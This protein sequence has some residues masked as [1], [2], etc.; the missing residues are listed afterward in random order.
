MSIGAALSASTV[1]K[2]MIRQLDALVV[3]SARGI[4]ILV[5]ACS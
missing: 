3:H 1:P 2:P 5:S 4:E